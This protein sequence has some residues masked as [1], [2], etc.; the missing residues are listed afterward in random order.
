MSCT[1]RTRSNVYARSLVE[2]EMDLLTLNERE[3]LVNPLTRLGV[4]DETKR[5]KKLAARERVRG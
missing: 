4:K 1:S 2:G 5:S 3:R